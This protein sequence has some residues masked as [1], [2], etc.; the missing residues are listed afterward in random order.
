MTCCSGT[1]LSSLYGVYP[2]CLLNY[3][4]DDSG[5]KKVWMLKIIKLYVT[6]CIFWFSF[7]LQGCQVQLASVSRDSCH[8][9]VQYV[10]VNIF[11]MLY[12]NTHTRGTRVSVSTS[13]CDSS[14]CIEKMLSSLI[15]CL[16]QYF[17]PSCNPA[18]P[19]RNLFCSLTA[20]RQNTS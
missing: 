14:V 9:Y 12:L 20:N 7:A 2:A 6:L 3:R 4:H 1:T 5:E 17:S 18:P 13:H 10:D 16:S 8:C 11:Q 19:Q 15:I